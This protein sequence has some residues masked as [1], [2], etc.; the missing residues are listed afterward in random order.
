MHWP[1]SGAKARSNSV[2]PYVALKLILKFNIAFWINYLLFIN[3]L[4]MVLS[5]QH[6]HAEM[7]VFGHV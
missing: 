2:N 4:L 1:M 5:R 3:D 7:R 6:R